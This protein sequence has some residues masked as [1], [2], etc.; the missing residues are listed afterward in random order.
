MRLKIFW[1]KKK[2]KF[3][4]KPIVILSL[5]FIGCAFAFCLA[6]VMVRK[7]VNFPLNKEYGKFLHLSGFS[8][9]ERSIDDELFWK[10]SV[11]F[12]GIKHSRE[13]ERG[14]FRIIC[15]GDSMTQGHGIHGSSLP[16]EQTYVFYL[17]KTLE[18]SHIDKKFEIINAGVGGYSSLQGLRYLE[19]K[20]IEF[21]PDLVISWFGVND[22]SDA[23]FFADKDQRLS[24]KVD[25]KADGLL[26]RSKLYL[27]FKNI[28]FRPN[29]KRVSTNDYYKNCEKMLLLAKKNNFEIAFVAPVELEGKRIEYYLPYKKVLEKLKSKYNCITIELRDVLNLNSE[30]DKFFIDNCHAT[31]EGNKLI[32]ELIKVSLFRNNVME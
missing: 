4:V 12:R 3:I 32:A 21:N 7:F 31:A 22:D 30:I 16:R 18:D 8:I 14:V 17:K 20:L 13:K 29:L 26:E 24:S 10:L 5:I 11:E 2:Q 19:G 6:E 9:P 28:I 27:F 23:L 15:L 25:Q 1:V